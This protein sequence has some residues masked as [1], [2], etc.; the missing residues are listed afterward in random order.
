MSQ[1]DFYGYFDGGPVTVGLTAMGSFVK[2]SMER[3]RSV[4]LSGA[5]A[6]DLARF[7]IHVA[8]ECSE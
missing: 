5:E 7:L 2:V 3:S 4:A 8:A 6:R 1:R